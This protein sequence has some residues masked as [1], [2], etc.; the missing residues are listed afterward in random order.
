MEIALADLILRDDDIPIGPQHDCPYLP[1]QIAR[2][3]AFVADTMEPVVYHALMERGYRRSGRVYY[4]PACESCAECVPMRI[5]VEAF[6]PSRSQR[7]VWRRNAD[8]RIE[9]GRPIPRPDRHALFVRYL[10][11]QHD[12]TMS[13]SYEDFCDYLCHSAVDTR[14]VSFRLGETLVGVGIIDICPFSVSTVYFYFDPEQRRRS[15]GI[16]SAL[17]EIRYAQEHGVPY[18]YLGYYV[19]D[20]RTMR[21]KARFRPH[22]RLG[23]DGIWRARENDVDV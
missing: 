18:Y 22:E 6:R 12:G 19:R 8:L 5:P 1:G 13:G 10:E 23:V 7:R 4:K 14:E 16:Y 2:E 20:A 15:L 9:V 11:Y 3:R 17:W 21:Y